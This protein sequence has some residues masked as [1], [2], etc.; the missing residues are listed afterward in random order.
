M[1]F[2]EQLDQFVERGADIYSNEVDSREFDYVTYR[3]TSGVYAAGAASLKPIVLKLYNWLEEQVC[4]HMIT[5]GGF[6]SKRDANCDRCNLLAEVE[7]MIG[8]GK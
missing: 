5:S 4:D 6:N 7:Q 2:S 1:N 3:T 8:E